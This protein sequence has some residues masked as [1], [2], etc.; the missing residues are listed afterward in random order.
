MREARHRRRGVREARAFFRSRAARDTRRGRLVAVLCSP[1]SV[2]QRPSGIA[3]AV[4]PPLPGRGPGAVLDVGIQGVDG[5][6]MVRAKVVRITRKG[7]L[8]HEV[9]LEF[10]GVAD[11]VRA[12]LSALARQAVA[13]P[14]MIT[15][16]AAA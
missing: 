12:E 2:T 8:G 9:G 7:L 10:E 4:A 14:T 13:C 11:N 1:V 15:Y 16:R 3:M 5:P 6:F